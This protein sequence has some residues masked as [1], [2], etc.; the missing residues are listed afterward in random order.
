MEVDREIKFLTFIKV[1]LRF[2]TD[3]TN[4]SVLI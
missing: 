3:K 1:E 2:I 4:S